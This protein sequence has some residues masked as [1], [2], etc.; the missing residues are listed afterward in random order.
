VSGVLL[1][2]NGLCKRFDGLAALTDVTF[3]VNA[4]ELVGLVGPN[5]AGKSTL[6]N[7]IAGVYAPSEGS[8]R[9]AG[10]NITGLASHTLAH[11]GLARTFQL[12]NLFGELTALE[13]VRQGL[14]RHTPARTCSGLLGTRAYRDEERA[15]D[16]RAQAVLERLDLATL[17]NERAAGLPL[18][19]QRLL[20]VAIALATEPRLLLLDEPAAGLSHEEATRLMTLVATEVRSRCTVLLVEHN[21]RLVSGYC[22]RAVVLH[23]GRKIYDGTPAGLAAD[24]QVVEAY[25]GADA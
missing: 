23:F 8:V 18:G 12:V 19:T 3:N 16:A 9:F 13:N 6:F 22:D 2:V 21:M 4:G 25:L 15:L 10:E 20:S 17:S 11:R 7:T 5:G 1:E 14:H 24:R